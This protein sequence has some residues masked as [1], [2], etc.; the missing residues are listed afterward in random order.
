MK[1]YA[2]TEIFYSLQ[3]EGLRAGT[4][5]V[6]VRFAGCNLACTK[7]IEGFDCDT[8]F[9][10]KLRLTA[11]EILEEV[12]KF[13]S[14][15]RWIVLTGGEPTLQ[16]DSNLV[17]I[18]H[19]AGYFLAIE[20]NG[21]KELPAT[22][23]WV[24][25]SPKPRTKIV[26]KCPDEIKVILSTGRKPPSLGDLPAAMNGRYLV[27]PAFS[28]Q[29]IDVKALAWCIHLVKEDPIWRLSVQAHKQWGV[30]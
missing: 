29:A 4:A 10:P 25:V 23:D 27:S 30:R 26:V 17:Q 16:L 11:K 22:L 24:S 1:R 9:S 13:S 8:D 7:A 15:C 2:L 6:F 14:V 19:E 28:G 5:A 20:T 21:T 12:K 18:L 3:G